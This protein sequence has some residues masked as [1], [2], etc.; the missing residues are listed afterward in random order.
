M[1][2]QKPVKMDVK[3]LKVLDNV[4]QQRSGPTSSFYADKKCTIKST[5][6]EK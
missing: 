6:I 5:P 1:L 4:S 2:L 3:M